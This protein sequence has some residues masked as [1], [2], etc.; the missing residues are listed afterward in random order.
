MII[1]FMLLIISFVVYA[2]VGIYAIYKDKK[3]PLNRTFLLLNLSFAVMALGSAFM[4][5]SPEKT[6]CFFWINILVIGSFSFPSFALH[7]FLIFSERRKL[8][9]KWWIYVAIYLP[10]FIFFTLNFAISFYAKDFVYTKYG[11]IMVARIDSIVFWIYNLYYVASVCA[12]VISSYLWMIKKDSKREKIKGKIIVLTAAFNL[13]ISGVLFT[14]SVFNPNIPNLGPITI[15]LWALGM[16]YGIVKYKLLKITPELAADQILET[17]NESVVIVGESGDIVSANRETGVLLGYSDEEILGQPLGMLFSGDEKFEKANIKTLFKKCPI[18]NMETRFVS[19]GN[20]KIPV[21]FSASECRDK[22][23]ELL[24]YIAVTRDITN[25]KEAEERLNYLAHHDSLT[26]LPNRLL[27]VDRFNQEAAKAKRNKTYLA[28]FLLDLDH[29]KQIN[30][31]YGHNAGDQLLV[32][33]SNRLR[34]SIRQSDSIARL[35]GDEFVILLSDLKSKNDYKATADRIV[36]NIA[37]PYVIGNKELNVTISVGVSIYPV[38]G[39]NLDSL[40]K[41]SDVAMYS[42]KSGGRNNYKLFTPVMSMGDKQLVDLKSELKDSLS[43]NEM[44]LYY[45]PMVDLYSEKIIGAEALVR[46]KHPKYGIISPS[47]FIPQAEENGL[48]GP[49][50]EWVLKTACTQ[51]KKWQESGFGPVYVSVN[52]SFFQF[53]EQNL[54]DTVLGILEES[55]LSPEYLLLEIAESN[56]VRDREN[57]GS[58]FKKLHEHKV[59]VVISGFGTGYSSLLYL[60]E[61]PIYAIKIDRFFIRNIANDPGC[62][63]IVK[64]II[65]LAHDLDVKVIAEGIETTEQREYLRSLEWK[66]ANPIKCDGAQGFL[67]SKPVSEDSM[68]ELFEKQREENNNNS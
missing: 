25:I 24:G 21:I 2:T 43:K 4:V 31:S 67:F 44:L 46:W 65:S 36:S 52:L 57:V 56:I 23:G 49:L 9:K 63:T 15:T 64:A 18:D 17:I 19:K 42:V 27:F 20:K 32:D 39:T 3:S 14:L 45:Q 8:L 35:G 62:A 66:P 60:K 38:N 7:F 26:S 10:F 28:V 16:L 30:D 54:A 29:F 55:G 37:K 51:A 50:G 41:D 34:E 40:L 61:F 59:M 6:G 48:I 12:G 53:R 11:W 1:L 13:V 68:E 33:V 47:E 5:V 22:T 58:V